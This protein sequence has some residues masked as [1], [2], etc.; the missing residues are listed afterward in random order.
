MIFFFNWQ[1]GKNCFGPIR[2][3]FS[4]STAQTEKNWLIKLVKTSDEFAI[5]Q[6]WIMHAEF[7]I[8]ELRPLDEKS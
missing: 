1:N 8:H 6:E 3:L 7:L 5:G 2:I 4:F